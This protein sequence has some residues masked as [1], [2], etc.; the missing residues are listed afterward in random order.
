MPTYIKGEKVA[1]ATS[2]ELHE[3]VGGIYTKLATNTDIDFE[4]SALGLNDGEHTL[5]V[6]A[7]ANGYEDS[8]YSN[9]VVFVCGY[10][11]IPVAYEDDYFWNTQAD[12]AVKTQLANNYYWASEE[13]AVSEGDEFHITIQIGTS[14]KTSGI[15]LTDDSYNIIFKT[16]A[17]GAIT[18]LDEFITVPAG[19][20][21]LLLTP[22]AKQGEDVQ[23]I[24]KVKKKV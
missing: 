11:E 13:I 15:A 4:V 3:K 24:V 19:A 5:V 18:Q 8:D 23:A 22:Y 2:Y 10:I 7:K 14:T 16:T 17:T 21:K 9:E 12:T 1:N 6:K 20:T